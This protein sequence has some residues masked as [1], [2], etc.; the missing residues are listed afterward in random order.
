MD[1]YPR[2]SPWTHGNIGDFKTT[3]DLTTFTGFLGIGM[4]M[5]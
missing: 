4:R 3:W 5:H 1:G 2:R